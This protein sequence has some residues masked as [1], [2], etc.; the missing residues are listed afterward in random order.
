MCVTSHS[1]IWHVIANMA[2]NIH[3]TGS[4][5]EINPDVSLSVSSL[6]SCSLTNKTRFS[7]AFLLSSM[8]FTA[9]AVPLPHNCFLDVF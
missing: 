4:C 7:S 3:G 2:G 9:M 6:H 1:S 8:A 5:D